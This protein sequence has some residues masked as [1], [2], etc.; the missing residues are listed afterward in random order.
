MMW[1]GG[2]MTGSSDTLKYA[3]L[4]KIAIGDFT[5]YTFEGVL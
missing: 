2:Y 3:L 5:T 4:A 1:V